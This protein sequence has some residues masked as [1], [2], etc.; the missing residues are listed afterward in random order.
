MPRY[1]YR[2]SACENEFEI[3]HGMSETQNEC[4]ECS[5]VGQLT[6]IPQLI[7]RVEIRD[8]KAT[9]KD[10]VVAAIEENR[11]TLRK[12]KKESDSYEFT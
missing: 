5:T 10:K 4:L 6:R 2:C 8:K 1:C 12:M 7:Q 9:P 3:R 11:D